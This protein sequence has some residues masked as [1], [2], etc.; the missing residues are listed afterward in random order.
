MTEYNSIKAKMI[1]MPRSEHIRY[2]MDCNHFH[3]SHDNDP[4]D[5][6]CPVCAQI[7]AAEDKRGEEVLELA[8]TKIEDLKSKIPENLM[9]TP[10]LMTL[11][12]AVTDIAKAYKERFGE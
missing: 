9:S 1:M 7:K 4:E 3:K 11:D 8:C 6:P 5:M 10:T 2:M 12:I